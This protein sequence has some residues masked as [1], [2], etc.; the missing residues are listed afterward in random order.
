MSTQQEKYEPLVT[1]HEGVKGGFWNEENQH[2]RFQFD[3]G[4][5]VSVLRTDEISTTLPDFNPEETPLGAFEACLLRTADPLPQALGIWGSP[6]TDHPDLFPLNGGYLAGGLS[7]VEVND[8]LT[9]VS[10]FPKASA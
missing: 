9:K 10:Q 7:N 4:Y 8:L 6:V 2:T 3:N 1:D 5:T